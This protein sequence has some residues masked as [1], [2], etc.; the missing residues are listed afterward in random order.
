MKPIKTFYVVYL[1]LT[2]F[3]KSTL[4][5]LKDKYKN[6]TTWHIFAFRMYNI[7]NS[8]VTKHMMKI[9]RNRCFICLEKVFN[10]KW[11]Y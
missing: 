7:Y 6:K 11:E 2:D 3:K 10:N 4:L 9:K 8:L 5:F 1:H